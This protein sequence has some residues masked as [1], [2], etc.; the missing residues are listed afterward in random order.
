MPS[1]LE[2]NS[3]NKFVKV[4]YFLD[5]ETD[6]SDVAMTVPEY[7]EWHNSTF[8][9]F[10]HEFN[11]IPN[12]DDNFSDMPPSTDDKFPDEDSDDDM[13][14]PLESFSDAG[15]DGESSD[16]EHPITFQNSSA[17]FESLHYRLKVEEEKEK[18][19]K[20]MEREMKEKGKKMNN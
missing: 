18:G 19:K 10:A 3:D 15:S 5:V 1:A 8:P 4:M 7:V 20:R 13:P 6:G 17:Y 14:P 11:M 12:M 2:E 9:E 16:S